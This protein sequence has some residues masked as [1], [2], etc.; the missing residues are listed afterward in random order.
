MF[1]GNQS[2]PQPGFAQGEHRSAV[3]LVHA[4]LCLPPRVPSFVP[5]IEVCPANDY[6][7]SNSSRLQRQSKGSSQSASEPGSVSLHRRQRIRGN[8]C[9]QFAVTVTFCPSKGP[10][11]TPLM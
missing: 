11:E 6:E 4:I 7:Y 10:T 2:F 5:G 3:R 9:R 8:A 1:I